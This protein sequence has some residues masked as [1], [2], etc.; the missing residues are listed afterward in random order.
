MQNSATASSVGKPG[1]AELRRQPA[2]P[3]S[4]V[5]WFDGISL[6]DAAEVGGKGANL[7]ELSRAGLPVPPGFVLGASAF[8]AA[9]EGAGI[10]GRLAALFAAADPDRPADLA[11]SV[12]EMRRLIQA[13]ALPA[14]GL[15]RAPGAL[16]HHV[17]VGERRRGRRGPRRHRAR[18]AQAA[19]GGESQ[20]EGPQW[21][22]RQ[23]PRPS[24]RLC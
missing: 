20:E 7:G 16:R 18:R 19:A 3:S 15:R 1:P 11:A 6:D 21:T 17:G 14:P 24:S 9:V 23:K 8:H 10:D 12:A 13:T 2:A 4:F 5:R 22:L